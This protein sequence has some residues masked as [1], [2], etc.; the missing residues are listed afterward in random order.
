MLFQI[1]KLYSRGTKKFNSTEG[2][3]NEMFNFNSELF[4]NSEQNNN[5]IKVYEN[6]TNIN[7]NKK[8]WTDPNVVNTFKGRNYK[9]CIIY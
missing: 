3:F 1:Q 7:T 5:D 9:L 6:R 8:S 4:V 2:S